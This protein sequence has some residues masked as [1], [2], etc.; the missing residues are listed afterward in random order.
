MSRIGLNVVGHIG[1]GIERAKIYLSKIAE[2][3]FPSESAEWERILR[4]R[5][6]RN[7]LVHEAGYLDEEKNQHRRVKE[8]SERRNSGLSIEHY[9]RDRINFA[10]EF[11]PGVLSTLRKFYEHLIAAIRN[12]EH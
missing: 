6:L 11:V 8:F 5:D 4:F 3:E 12:I 7:V 1:R 10:P 2:I 9:A